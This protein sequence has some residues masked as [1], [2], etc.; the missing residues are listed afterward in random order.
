MDIQINGLFGSIDGIS[1]AN[2]SYVF[3]YA[4]IYIENV[5]N[6]WFCI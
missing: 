3:I 5:L 2:I 6:N 1:G 4:N